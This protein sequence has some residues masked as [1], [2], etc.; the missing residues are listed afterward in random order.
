[1]SSCPAMRA[2]RA[3]V[4]RAGGFP[5]MV[6]IERS[7]LLA[8]TEDGDTTRLRAVHLPLEAVPALQG[9]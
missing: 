6:T 9:P 4:A 5:K 8:W 3:S 2:A 1:M 7:L